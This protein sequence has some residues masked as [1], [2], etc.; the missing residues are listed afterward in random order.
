M[1]ASKSCDIDLDLN[2]NLK[3]YEPDG[4]MRREYTPLLAAIAAGHEKVVGMLLAHPNGLRSLHTSVAASEYGDALP[5]ERLR[6][7]AMVLLHPR[8]DA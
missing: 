2:L 5:H 3:M 7:S 8:H 4:S 1:G 6:R